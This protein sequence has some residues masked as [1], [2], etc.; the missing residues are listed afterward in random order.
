M[1]WLWGWRYFY[2]LYLA[3]RS[4]SQ[5]G[6][7]GVNDGYVNW[8][9]WLDVYC[10]IYV[11]VVVVVVVVVAKALVLRYRVAFLVSSEECLVL[12]EAPF[13]C[14]SGSNGA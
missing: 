6:W 10:W 4:Y 9:S 12:I 1:N 14:C 3:L 5:S 11:V 2:G 8:V 7:C 13:V